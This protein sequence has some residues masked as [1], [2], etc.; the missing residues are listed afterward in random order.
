MRRSGIRAP[1]RVRFA[2]KE[3]RPFVVT[4]AQSLLCITRGETR[5]RNSIV[6]PERDDGDLVRPCTS[7]SSM[8]SRFIFSV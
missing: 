8:S 7:N 2:E 1:C 6:D 4:D 5:V 3:N